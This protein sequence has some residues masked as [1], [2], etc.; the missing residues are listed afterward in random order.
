MAASGK[1]RDRE[2]ATRNT[3]GPQP[4]SEDGWLR[5]PASKAATLDAE[6]E[7]SL[8]EIRSASAPGRDGDVGNDE[9]ISARGTTRDQQ[10]GERSA[11]AAPL[12]V[13]FVPAHATRK[14]PHLATG[15]AQIQRLI[16]EIVTSFRIRTLGPGSAEVHM[17]IRSQVL[18]GASVKLVST[19]GMISARLS[20]EDVATQR[21][22]EGHVSRLK[23]ELEARGLALSE[24]SVVVEE[25]RAGTGANL[26]ARDHHNRSGGRD[27]ALAVTDSKSAAPDRAQF[28]PVMPSADPS[29]YRL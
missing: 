7:H 12:G 3:S 10:S 28:D 6:S 26:G 27:S 4:R 22:A 23:A 8:G 16:E 18:P 25:Q 1:D 17:T 14:A 9:G 15:R 11:D 20:V 13:D 19:K 24:I 2:G 29:Y 5:A 21:F